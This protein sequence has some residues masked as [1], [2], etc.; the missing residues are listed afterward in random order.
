MSA[1]PSIGSIYGRDLAL[2]ESLFL[3]VSQSGQSPDLVANANWAKRN[4]AFVVA[5]VNDVGSPVAAAA[6]EVLP[7]QA[8][9][10]ASVAAT[11][12]YIAS[13]AAL[14]QLT[15][16][17]SASQSLHEALT[18]LPEQLSQ[19]LTLDWSR[20][21][22]PFAS[23]GDLLVVGRGLSFGIANE[24]ALKFKETAAIHAEAFSGA[25]LMH[26]PLAL[27]RERYPLLVF[28]QDDETRPSVEQLL[29]TLREK[30]ARV[31][32]A[33]AGEAAQFRLPVVHGM[34]PATAPLAMI[35]TF[36][37]LANAIA[38]A[39]GFNPDHPPHLRKVTETQ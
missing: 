37:L 39:R 28:S 20:A 5:V 2:D 15:A 24:A 8:G 35:Q 7:L 22:V 16:F 3:I 18:A 19:A 13:L 11:K 38:L 33:Q 4:G 6:D 30:G 25:E 34:H 32:A 14:A 31:Y 12:T 36:Y 23:A 10:E 27:V 9:A 26:G 21:I 1:A 29:E 17:L